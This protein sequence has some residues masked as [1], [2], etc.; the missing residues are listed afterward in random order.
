MVFRFKVACSC[1]SN[2]ITSGSW[3]KTAFHIGS[4][5]L[6]SVAAS[7]HAQHCSVAEFELLNAFLCGI[8]FESDPVSG[9]MASSPAFH[10]LRRSG[11]NKPQSRGDGTFVWDLCSAQDALASRLRGDWTL[12]RKPGD[13]S[14]LFHCFQHAHPDMT[15]DRLREIT[16][17]E[18]HAW[19]V[20]EI[21]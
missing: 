9:N 18:G 17:C 10:R 1:E 16:G 2:L 11:E 6:T 3:M 20:R 13:G 12:V 8:Q 5:Q 14:C 19:G 21:T 7:M 15:V 4:V